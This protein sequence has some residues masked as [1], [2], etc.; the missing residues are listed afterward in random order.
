MYGMLQEVMCLSCLTDMNIGV[1][2][3]ALSQTVVSL[4]A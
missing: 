1:D 2:E 3:L 4:K